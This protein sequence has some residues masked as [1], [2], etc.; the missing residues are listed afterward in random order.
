LLKIIARK[1]VF[2]LT[3]TSVFTLIS[4]FY[5]QSITPIYRATVGFLAPQDPL[6]LASTVELLPNEIAK[7][8]ANNKPTPF[9]RFLANIKS[10]KLKQVVFVNGGFQKKFFRETE[11]DTDQSALAIYNSIKI[12]KRNGD[13]YLEL[14]GSQPKVM[15]EFVTALVEAAKENVNTEINDIALSLFNTRVNTKINNLSTQIENLQQAI[16]VQKQRTKEEKANEI[17]R[18]SKALITAKQ[19]GIKNNNFNSAIRSPRDSDRVP[20]WFLYGELALQNKINRLKSEEGIPNNSQ[21]KRKKATIKRLQQEIR[22]LRSKKEAISNT[23]NLAIKERKLKRLQTADLPLLK[24]KIVTIGEYG[25]SLTNPGQFWI[26]VGS[27]IAFGLLIS[28]IMAL[29]IHIGKP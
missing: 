29:L 8:I 23:K 7:Q 14:E 6:S 1:K 3:V 19:M 16:T 5:A 2:I 25:Y 11:I 4:I 17:V 27:G 28:T 22:S 13:T 10:Y 12:V 24:F 20:L 26:I 9:E 21:L 15:L 18:L